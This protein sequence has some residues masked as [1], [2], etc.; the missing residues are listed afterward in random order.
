[1]L[2]YLVGVLISTVLCLLYNKYRIEKYNLKDA[3]TAFAFANQTLVIGL[4]SWVGVAL[5]L[6]AVLI[7]YINYSK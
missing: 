7:E 5:T 1:M 3:K 4:F 6:L 2:T